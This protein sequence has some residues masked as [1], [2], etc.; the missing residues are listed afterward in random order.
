MEICETDMMTTTVLTFVTLFELALGSSRGL[1]P[2]ANMRS[3]RDSLDTV[4]SETNS[5]FLLIPGEE[6]PTILRPTTMQPVASRF[7]A[8]M[9]SLPES[10][11]PV[12]MDAVPSI[13]VSVNVLLPSV[14]DYPGLLVEE[15]VEGITFIWNGPGIIKV[16][17]CENSTRAFKS[18]L[19][20]DDPEHEILKD[21]M[22]TAIIPELSG[23]PLHQ[24]KQCI[25]PHKFDSARIWLANGQI[26]N[27]FI[28]QFYFFK[29]ARRSDS[30]RERQK[31]TRDVHA[32]L[33][34]IIIDSSQIEYLLG[35]NVS[36]ARFALTAFSPITSESG[37]AVIKGSDSVIV[38]K[39]D[40]SNLPHRL[41]KYLPSKDEGGFLR[42]FWDNGLHVEN[43]RAPCVAVRYCGAKPVD[44]NVDPSSFISQ[45]ILQSSNPI[46][47]DSFRQLGLGEICRAQGFSFS[48]LLPDILFILSNF[49]NFPVWNGLRPFFRVTADWTPPTQ[50]LQHLYRENAVRY[51]TAFLV[52]DFHGNLKFPDRRN[53]LS[54]D[55][56]ILK[57]LEIDGKYYLKVTGGDLEFSS[58]NSSKNV[59]KLPVFLKFRLNDKFAYVQGVGHGWQARLTVS[60]FLNFSDSLKL[61][62]KRI[63]LQLVSEGR[64]SVIIGKTR[65]FLISEKDIFPTK[66]IAQNCMEISTLSDGK[67]LLTILKPKGIA[68]KNCAPLGD[69]SCLLSSHTII[70]VSNVA[71]ITLLGTADSEPLSKSAQNMAHAEIIQTKELDTNH[72]SIIHRKV[73]S[74]GRHSDP[75]GKR[76]LIGVGS[77]LAF[78]VVGISIIVTQHLRYAASSKNLTPSNNTTSAIVYSS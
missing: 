7:R 29:T 45:S 72:P 43:L 35:G 15:G 74:T 44:E 69:N 51:P 40:L 2:T 67:Y 8:D 11:P 66:E 30:I 50:S 17:G 3:L 61:V 55:N 46:N 38:G 53:N 37:L 62:D 56:V 22:Q 76:I 71:T 18:R 78:C 73:C 75:M 65:N 39:E 58:Q 4:M 23:L 31:L 68:V 57:A 19:S 1:H 16:I 5:W 48:V 64:V 9:Q 47:S 21:L 70:T 32:A 34:A 54:F 36:R 28:K 26:Q 33:K 25:L 6:V 24:G 10:S 63:R 59:F 52:V 49:D 13:E 41:V 12:Q 60:N 77:L 42:F 20:A 14:S 27:P